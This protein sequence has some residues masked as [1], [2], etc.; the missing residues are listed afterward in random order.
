L[1]AAMANQVAGQAEYRAMC[2]NAALHSENL[3][4]SEG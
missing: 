3:G 4:G 2:A 1:V